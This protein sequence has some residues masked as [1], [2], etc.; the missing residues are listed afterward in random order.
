MAL[1]RLGG[2]GKACGELLRLAFRYRQLTWEMTRREITDRYAG[3]IIGS[4]WAFAHPLLLMGVY[5][6]LFAVVMRVEVGGTPD[7]PFDYPTYLLAGLIPWIAC[8]E[9]MSKGVVALTASANLVKQVVF[10]LEVLPI[11]GVLAALFTQAISLTLLA[12]YLLLRFHMLP[13]S[14]LLIPLLLLLQGALLV[15]I[16]CLLAAI[17]PYFR[18]LKDFV[19]VYSMVGVYLMPV[20]YLPSMVPALFRPVL[21]FNPLSYLVWCYQDAC[22]Y[23]RIQHVKAWGVLT[24][25]AFLSLAVGYRVFRSLKPMLGNVL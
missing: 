5:V 6:F 16:S 25:L 14:F 13:W 15:G 11:K 4:L 7:M 21:Y 23:G 17:G 8:A 22:F 18:D 10:P 9:V 12:C 2:N 1:L 19:Q 20:A 3:Q 24:L